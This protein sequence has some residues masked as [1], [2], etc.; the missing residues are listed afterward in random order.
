MNKNLQVSVVMGVYNGA[1]ILRDTVQS[2]LTQ[3]DV[4]LEFIIVNDGSTDTSGELLDEFARTDPRVRVIHQNNAG[5]T[6]ALIKGCAAAQGEYIARQDAGDLFLPG[7]LKKQ[8]DAL[9]SQPDVV[10]VSC[11]TRFLGPAGEFLY[12]VMPNG[13]EATSRL[14]SL[15]SGR[16]RGPS[17][18]ASV[19]FRRDQYH[20]VGG[21]RK[22]F[23]FA[24]DIDLWTRL[25]EVGRHFI[26][27]EVLFQAVFLPQSISGLQRRRQLELTKIIVEC[28]RRR[29]SGLGEHEILDQASRI[30]PGGTTTSFIDQ[31]NALYFIGSCLRKNRDPLAR[32]YF[33]KAW[34][35]CPCHVKSAL[36][37]IVGR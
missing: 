8:L 9:T 31:A 12:D 28:S 5:L 11:G 22:Q 17:H 10:L 21:Y 6:M 23:Y 32:E 13:L 34:M 26:V 15:D 2:V 1:H 3:D 18:H 33:R 19:V 14:L 20:C 30:V 24:Q 16:L 7:K 4:D 36:R 29:R 35:A 25:A 37:L 27:P